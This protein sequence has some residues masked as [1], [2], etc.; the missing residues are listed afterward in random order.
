MLQT[1][2]IEVYRLH[3]EEWK[4]KYLVK[5]NGK[6]EPEVLGRVKNNKKK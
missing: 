2:E 3:E 1:I 5:L 6:K 4:E